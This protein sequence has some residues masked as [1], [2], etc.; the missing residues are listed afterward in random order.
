MID[1]IN[2]IFILSFLAINF[3]ISLWGIKKG[4]K[5]ESLDMKREFKNL[6]QEFKKD[7]V[8]ELEI[9][10]TRI[11]NHCENNSKG[12]LSSMETLLDDFEKRNNINL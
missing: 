3:G 12:A 8:S 9:A 7:Q 6:L 5:E 4:V 10:I 11:K 2:L 1:G